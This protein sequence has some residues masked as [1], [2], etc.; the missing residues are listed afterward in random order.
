MNENVS[1]NAFTSIDESGQVPTY[2]A[3][4]ESFDR[5]AE[6]QELKQIERAGLRLGD[7][8]LDVGCGPGLETSVLARRVGP[9]GRICGLDKSAAFIGEA[10]R[11]AA[12][13]DL[14]IDYEVGSADALPWPQG[15]F[16]HVRA[17][18]VLIYLDD[19]TGALSEMHRVLRPGGSL[20]LIEPQLDTVT[21]NL[22]DRALVRRVMAYDADTAAAQSWLPGRLPALL[23]SLGLGN[24]SISTRVLVFPQDLAMDYFVGAARKAAQADAISHGEFESWRQDVIGLRQSDGLFGTIGYFLFICRRA[25][26]ERSAAPL[27]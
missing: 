21:V 2:I 3:A 5:I 22:P 17:E 16:D 12:A 1:L 8:V 18:R 27:E 7:A 4:L 19:V 13:L 25:S 9:G 14:A 23:G 20:A 10:R 11:R 6:L 26:G 24:P 15:S